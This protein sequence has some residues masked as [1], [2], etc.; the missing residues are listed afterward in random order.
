MMKNVLPKMKQR[1]QVCDA[2]MLNQRTK[3]GLKKIFG[4]FT[5][6]PTKERRS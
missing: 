4:I 5:L 3:A 2:T 6:K 1:V